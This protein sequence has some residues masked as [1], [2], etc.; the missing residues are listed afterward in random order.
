LSS[1]GGLGCG[2]FD[3][4]GV[5]AAGEVALDDTEGFFLGLFVGVEAGHEG[6]GFG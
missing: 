3:E 4:D 1:G 5:E 6:L 2:G